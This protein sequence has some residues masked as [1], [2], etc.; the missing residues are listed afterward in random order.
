LC[1][2]VSL[3]AIG[4]ALGS[5]LGAGGVAAAGAGAAAA[6]G[7]AATI[8]GLTASQLALVSA[9]V[10][11]VGGLAAGYAKNQ[12]AKA[13]AQ[14]DNRNA[15]ISQNAANDAVERGDE[16]LRRHFQQVGQLRG[17]QRAALAANGVDVDFGSAADLQVDTTLAAQA[18][19]TIIAENAQREADSYRINASNYRASAA[20]AKAAGRTAMVAGAFDAGR[21]IL[22]GAQQYAS[23]KTKYGL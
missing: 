22:G 6:A 9:G 14:I 19:A 20:T 2:P 10:S 13:Q 12:Q 16:D 8:F 3:T 23:A 18:D 5:A 4:T 17:Q 21:S 11:A 7:S 15:S 1:E